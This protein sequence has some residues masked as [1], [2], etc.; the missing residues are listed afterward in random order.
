MTFKEVNIMA[1]KITDKCI[2]CGA[3]SAAEV[4]AKTTQY[5]LEQRGIDARA[6]DSKGRTVY[7]LAKLCHRDDTI[8]VLEDYAEKN[9][10]LIF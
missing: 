7:D 10:C 4:N 8:K 1:Y 6:V 3:C 2:S 5:L 9:S